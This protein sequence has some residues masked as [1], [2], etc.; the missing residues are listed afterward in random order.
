MQRGPFAV[1]APLPGRVRLSIGDQVVEMTK[2]ADD[3]WRPVEP[4]LETTEVDYGYLID[5]DETP[6]PD[7]RS[8]RQPHGVHERSRTFDPAAFGAAGQTTAKRASGSPATS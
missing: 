5:D 1:W 7:P 2:D 8:R 6:R 3:W 4:L